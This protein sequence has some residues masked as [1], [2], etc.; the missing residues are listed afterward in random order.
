MSR[1]KQRE[2]KEVIDP[3]EISLKEWEEKQRQADEDLAKERPTDFKSELEY[4]DFYYEHREN[5][6]AGGISPESHAALFRLS[7]PS[8]ESKNPLKCLTQYRRHVQEEFIDETPLG[9]C[10]KRPRD[11]YSIWVANAA[12]RR[13]GAELE[14][15]RPILKSGLRSLFDMLHAK[16]EKRIPMFDEIW[17]INGACQEYHRFV[18]GEEMVLLINGLA[19]FNPERRRLADYTVKT[20]TSGIIKGD[21]F[22]T[23]IGFLDLIAEYNR[24]VAEELMDIDTA[25][26]NLRG[27]ES[28]TG[29]DVREVKTAA[30][31][32]E[33][34]ATESKSMLDQIVGFFKAHIIPRTSNYAVTQKALSQLLEKFN[35][36]V[37]ERQIKRWEQ[38]IKT[39]GRKGTKPP[40]GYTL[41][42]RKTLAGA[43]AWA[44]N[45][46][47]LEKGRLNTKVSLEKRFGNNL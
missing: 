13:S 30:E 45:Y 3:D 18:R 25:L 15:L 39:N 21:L 7:K 33:T 14:R 16:R 2:A 35:A 46:A 26:T 41:E 37:T 43:T 20:K 9:K 8:V 29:D 19:D 34:A 24:L 17:K 11:S 42:T 36:K 4:L 10:A 44:K 32:A 6:F 28:A 47:D 5:G 22:D 31:G 27:W 38:F 12:R 23:Y 40:D 1:N